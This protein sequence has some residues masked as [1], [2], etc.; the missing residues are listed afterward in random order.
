MIYEQYSP[1]LIK[2]DKYG[3][4]FK[5]VDYNSCIFPMDYEI[6]KHFSMMCL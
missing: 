2:I 1:I 3:I 4:F 6:T 5:T